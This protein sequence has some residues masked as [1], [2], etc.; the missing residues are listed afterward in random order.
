MLKISTKDRGLEMFKSGRERG[1][2]AGIPDL[3]QKADCWG[4]QN[5]AHHLIL[6]HVNASLACR[7][8]EK[9]KTLCA[10]RGP[11]KVLVVELLLLYPMYRMP[12]RGTPC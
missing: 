9:E 1:H 8:R 5:L 3:D 10:P 6:S 2:S 4:P 7:E 11:Q 12:L